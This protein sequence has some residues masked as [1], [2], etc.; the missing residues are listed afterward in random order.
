M[1]FL[2]K[3][4]VIPLFTFSLILY[5][6]TTII[7]IPDIMAFLLFLICINNKEFIKEMSKSTWI[8]IYFLISLAM[9]L[10]LISTWIKPFWVY[11]L[12]RLVIYFGAG[13]YIGSK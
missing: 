8:A 7:F 13:Y 2:L 5:Q 11:H 1:K 3:T 6:K 10:L 9:G 12:I 4:L